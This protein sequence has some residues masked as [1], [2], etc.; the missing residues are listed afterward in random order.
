MASPNNATENDVDR[1]AALKS[2]PLADSCQLRNPVAIQ[3]ATPS[4]KESLR[5]AA[6]DLKKL[7]L[8]KSRSF[9]SFVIRVTLFADTDPPS[10]LPLANMRLVCP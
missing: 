10:Q 4:I 3:L 5:T 1:G 7:G 6:L 9:I 2:S 8:T